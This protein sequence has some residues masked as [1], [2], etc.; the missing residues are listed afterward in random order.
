M[1]HV[2]VWKFRPT[3]GRVQEFARAYSSGGDWAQLF[4]NAPGFQGTT[5]MSPA[6]PDEWW[7]TL[8]R[9]E[10]SAKFDAF[11]QLFGDQYRALDAK[12]EDISGE[13]IFVGA[14]EDPG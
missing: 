11:V 8:D 3:E 6:A 12:L 4:R 1:S 7:L 2:R 13:E 5:L 9:W 10:S 14:F